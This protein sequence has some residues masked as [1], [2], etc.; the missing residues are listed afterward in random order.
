MSGAALGGRLEKVWSSQCPRS[1]V[2]VPSKFRRCFQRGPKTEPKNHWIFDAFLAPFGVHLASI[3][4]PFWDDFPLQFWDLFSMR[5]F[6]ILA[7]FV[8]T[9]TL[10][11]GALAHTPCD[12]SSFRH[13]AKSTKKTSKYLQNW[14]QNPPQNQK[15]T[16][17]KSIKK[18][19][20][21]FN[22]VYL[23]NGPKMT[24]KWIEPWGCDRGF[25]GEP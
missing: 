7:S 14:F 21:F 3:L 16:T 20:W 10:D 19:I 11:F 18:C 24:P 4:G 1:S 23:Q 2:E 22:V 12:F 6:L 15:T 5:F 9:P 17:K 25:C 8:I 13:V